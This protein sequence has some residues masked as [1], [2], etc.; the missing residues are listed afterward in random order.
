VRPRVAVAEE[1]QMTAD[2]EHAGLRK[3]DLLSAVALVVVLFAIYAAGASRTIYVGD[4]GEL[5]TAVHVLGVPHPTGYPLYVLLGKLWTLLLPVGSIAFRMSLFSSACAAAACAVLFLLCRRLGIGLAAALTAALSLAFA[6]SFWGEANVQRVYSL[7]ALFVVVTT[8]LACEW[9]LRREIR[10]FVATIF[11]G[12][13]GAANHTYMAIHVGIF[14]VFALLCAPAFVLRPRVL[15]AAALAG[16]TGL[17]PYVYLPVA[18]RFDPPLDWGNP[19]S[20]ESFLDVVLRRDFWERAWIEGPADLLVVGADYVVG[21]AR[22]LGW[23]GAALAVAGVA[24]GWRRRWLVLLLLLAMFGNVA[25]MALHGSRSDLFIWHRYYIPSTVMAALLLGIGADALLRRVPRALHALPL[26]V[27]LFLLVGGWQRFD[28]SDYRIAED[29]SRELLRTIPPG[30]SLAASDDNVLFVLIYLTMVE[31]LR[32]DLN[33]ILQG[34][35]GPGPPALRFDPATDPL[36]FTHHPNWN[37]PQLDVVPMGLAFRVWN[38]DQ[39]PPDPVL[40][41]AELHSAL[42]PAVPKDYLTQNLIGHYYFMQGFTF[43]MRDW[44]RAKLNL[45]RA[46]REAAGNDVLFYNLGL[47]YQRNG[48]YD[49][50]RR[51]FQRSHVINPRHLASSKRARA[52]DRIADLDVEMN[53]IAAIESELQ[54]RAG[55]EPAEGAQYHRQMASLLEERG[56]SVAARGHRM[57]AQELSAE[58]VG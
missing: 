3:R 46:A 49:E 8:W 47:I 15:A 39:P 45:E 53:R 38:R 37:H 26:A 48:L 13:L 41:A 54:R 20:L 9:Y 55:I 35:G 19:E 24:A 33:L 21:L 25:S 44:T 52:A 14:A 11:V 56:E 16:L 27:P 12:S 43:E 10:L 28:R 23:L 50:A 18:S 30:A 42:D 36:Y 32:P 40:P 2:V 7:N 29:F 57:R 51:A 34:V 1:I 6:P 58:E 22:E 17:L 31:G 5:V 4:S